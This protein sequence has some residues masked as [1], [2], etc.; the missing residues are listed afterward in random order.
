[1]S[2]T[3]TAHKNKERGRPG[4]FNIKQALDDAMIV[5][6]QKRYH[7]ASISDLAEAM[8]LSA[9]S[10]YKAFKDKRSLFLLVFERY[11]RQRN[12]DLRR[13]LTPCISG[14]EKLPSFCSSIWIRHVPKKDGTAA[15]SLPAPLRCRRW[16]RNWRSALM[17]C[18]AKSAHAGLTAGAGATGWIDR[19]QP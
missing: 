1:M 17:R 16:F 5:F 15:W 18:A 11:L 7:A 8:N 19:K 2:T 13:R 4:E 6:R 10:I 9:G 12:T 3:A 14:R